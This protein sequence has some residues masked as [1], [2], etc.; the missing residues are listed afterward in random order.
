MR[1]ELACAIFGLGLA[2]AMWY[3]ADAIPRSALADAVGADGVPKR[4]AAALALVSL[5]IA[6]RALLWRSAP[7]ASPAVF[8]PRALAIPAIAGACVLAMPWIGYP[9]S[10][11]LLLAAAAEFYGAPSRAR[12]LAFAVAAAAVLWFVFGRLLGLALPSGPL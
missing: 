6:A 4:L 7:P 2:A 11:A 5:W 12:S 3:A 9:L 1:R 8:H 10:L